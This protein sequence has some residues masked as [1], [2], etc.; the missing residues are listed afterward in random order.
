MSRIDNKSCRVARRLVT[1]A[2][3]VSVL[4]TA[5][6][7][8][9]AAPGNP[10][11]L[12]TIPTLP[13][14]TQTVHGY[15]SAYAKKHPGSVP[16]GANNFSCT[17]DASH[18][19]PVI[20]VHGTDS[21]AYSDWALFAP[22]LAAAGNCVYALNYGSVE[23]SDTYGVGDIHTSGKQ[24]SDFVQKV[25]SATGADKVQL[26]GYSQ[27][28]VV[29]RYYVNKLGGSQ[30]VKTWVGLASPSYGGDL[31]GAIP[32]VRAVGAEK[33][34]SDMFPIALQQQAEGSDFLKELNSP[35]DTVPG[36]DYWTIGSTVDERIT[37]NENQA[38][39]GKGA[40]NVLIQDLCPGNM[41]GH[42]QLPYDPFAQQLMFNILSPADAQTPNC[43]DVPFGTGIPEVVANSN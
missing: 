15:A 12:T 34:V 41:S 42:M 11:A 17:P 31:Y 24:L 22:K 23:G 27:G 18:P 36:V 30:Y 6:S 21:D 35:S 26:V 16:P 37:P 32:V 14:P 10:S 2:A 13:G 9:I 25:R 3:A 33:Q 43:V 38:L 29:T 19:S 40:H 20:L 5:P 7:L 1:A 39:H 4:L 8:A 28:A